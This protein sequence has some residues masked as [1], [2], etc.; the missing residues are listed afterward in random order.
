MNNRINE[1][2]CLFGHLNY[3]KVKQHIIYEYNLVR[4]EAEKEYS[5]K[6]I[7]YLFNVQ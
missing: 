2:L 3:T 7:N 5:C 4:R 1:F 6:G